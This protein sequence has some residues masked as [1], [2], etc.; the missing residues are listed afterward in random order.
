MNLYAKGVLMIMTFVSAQIVSKSPDFTHFEIQTCT[1]RRRYG[2]AL[3]TTRI[4][5][6]KCTASDCW[7]CG[8]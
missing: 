7:P 3:G 5:M 8:I 2:A 1:G 4:I 6:E